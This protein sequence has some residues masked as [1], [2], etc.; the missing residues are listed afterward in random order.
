MRIITVFI[1]VALGLNV[2]S[3]QQG[4]QISHNYNNQFVQNPAATAIWDKTEISAYYSRAFNNVPNA[5]TDMFAGIQYAIP[6]QN[7]AVGASII[8]QSAG[9]TTLNNLSGSFSYKLKKLANRDDY[10]SFGLGLKINQLKIRGTEAIVIDNEDPNY[11]G[12]ESGIGINF[13]GG[14]FYS[15]SNKIG[16]RNSADYI[17]QFGAGVN[18][19]DRVNNLNSIYTYDEDLQINAFASMIMAGNLDMIVRGYVESIL[20][21][22]DQLNLTLGLRSTF[23]ESF[24]AGASF[25][26]F[27]NLGLELGYI[28]SASSTGTTNATVQFGIPFNETR[29]FVQPGVGVSF[30]HTLE[31][32]YY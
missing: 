28:F 20:L 30:L 17:F 13:Q 15:S 16:G 6:G 23:S 29:T 1:F 25:D 24:I 21:N 26:K 27:K 4:F 2:I 12:I 18:S 8:S 31:N 10:L 19:I 9:L 14:V 7:A 32:S 22:K 3:A 5:P 11:G